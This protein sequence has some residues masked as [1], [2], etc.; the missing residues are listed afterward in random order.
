MSLSSLN[1]EEKIMFNKK[2]EAFSLIEIIVALF[3]LSITMAG[4]ANIFISAKRYS[5]H[6]QCRLQAANLGR[7]LLDGLH[8]N[9]RRDQWDTSGGDYNNILSQGTKT[10]GDEW[11]G[12]P[13]INY[14]PTYE[15]VSPPAD[16][17]GKMRKVKLTLNWVEPAFW[18]LYGGG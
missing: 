10:L 11:L 4:V 8:I 15:I 7:W 12:Y 17:S 18:I 16:P 1:F 14:S 3:I 6:S 2:R 9:V 5:R 13:M